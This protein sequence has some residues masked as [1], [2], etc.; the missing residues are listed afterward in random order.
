MSALSMLFLLFFLG[1]AHWLAPILAVFFV[2]DVFHSTQ[3]LARYGSQVWLDRASVLA[4]IVLA[5]IVLTAFGI[6]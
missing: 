6:I 4:F 2:E 1:L 5:A 3:H